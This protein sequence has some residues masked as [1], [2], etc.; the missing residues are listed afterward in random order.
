[1]RNY[2]LN[3]AEFYTL[4]KTT[5]AKS[6]TGYIL[7]RR[8]DRFGLKNDYNR[9][10][11]WW[12]FQWLMTRRNLNRQKLKLGELKKKNE[13]KYLKSIFSISTCQKVFYTLIQSAWN[14]K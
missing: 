9:G 11:A 4:K 8:D 7:C 14:Q 1:M 2:H 3:Q 12:L 6:K 13:W 10:C 5:I